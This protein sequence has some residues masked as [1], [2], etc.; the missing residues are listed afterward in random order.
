MVKQPAVDSAHGHDG[1]GSA[2]GMRGGVGLGSMVMV[3]DVEGGSW[4][5]DRGTQVPRVSFG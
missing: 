4:R 5:E 2:G 3:C 1:A